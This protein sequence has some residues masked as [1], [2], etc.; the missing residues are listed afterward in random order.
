MDKRRIAI[1]A[2]G[3]S[4]EFPV[5][6]RSAQ[7]L[8]SFMDKDRY[9]IYIV[10]L[11]RDEWFVELPGGETSEID[12]NDF[13]FVEGDRIR[14]FDFVYITIHGTP[15]EDGRIQGYLDMIGLPYSTCDTLVSAM[16]FNKFVCNR[17][18]QAFGIP[19]AHSI[20]LRNGQ[21]IS[22]QEVVEQVGLPC[23]IKPN[24]GG[25]SCGATKVKIE[26]E[27]QPAIKKAFDEGKE[28]IIEAFMA[29]TEITCGCYKTRKR[30]VVLP[31]TEVISK[32]EFF[33]YEA[34]YTACK[35]E[36]ITPARL[37]EEMTA[38]V[39]ERT[40]L[41]YDIL[42]CKGIIRVDYIIV[43][44]EPYLLEVNTT[45][46]MTETSFIPQQVKAAGMEMKCVLSEIIENEMSCR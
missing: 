30:D 21:S 25:S 3:Y 32:N 11:T 27:I 4:S 43:G 39:Q 45:P 13:S 15:G 37:S 41:I 24:V 36:E 9:D 22:D 44:E 16:T 1:V 38:K 17:Y 46:G 8:Y 28:V 34:K 2:G 14:H 42:G 7:G 20:V 29:G 33:D 35:A 31:V 18:L 40:S 6:L 12:K 5:S 19:I 26:G 23:F 10:K